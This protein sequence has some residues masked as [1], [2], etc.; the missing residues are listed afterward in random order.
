[1]TCKNCT[2]EK[3]IAKEALLHAVAALRA[4]TMCPID[5]FKVPANGK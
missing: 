4:T 1:M 3:W 5:T 2:A